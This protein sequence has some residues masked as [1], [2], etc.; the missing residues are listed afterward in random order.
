MTYSNHRFLQ[1]K[2]T[3]LQFVRQPFIRALLYSNLAAFFLIGPPFCLSSFGISAAYSKRLIHLNSN[4]FRQLPPNGALFS[5]P[6]A[7]ALLL[8]LRFV[9]VWLLINDLLL[10]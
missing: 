6:F 1:S 3:S 5:M 2:P 8:D 7:F 10:G 4:D 9:F